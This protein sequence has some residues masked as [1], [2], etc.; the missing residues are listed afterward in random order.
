MTPATA[1]GISQQLPSVSAAKSN[2]SPQEKGADSQ[3]AGEVFAKDSKPIPVDTVSISYQLRQTANDVKKE[4][5]KKEE[6]NSVKNIDNS[7]KAAAKVQFV[8]DLK[9]DLSIRYMDNNNRLIYQVPSELMIRLSEAASRSD[10]S[11][12]TKA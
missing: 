1:S 4:E 12:D 7:G 8:Y 6:A 9:G 10:S 5:A 2:S 3:R 11:V